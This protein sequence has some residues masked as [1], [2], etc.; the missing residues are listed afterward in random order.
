MSKLDLETYGT[1]QELHCHT[2]FCDGKSTPEEMVLAAI[3]KGL[4]RIG[5]SGHAPMCFPEEYPMSEQGAED[6]RATVAALK[7]TYAGRIEI[8]CGI[9]QDIY[10]VPIAKPYD[11]VIGAAHY[12]KVGGEYIPVDLEP[13][14][15]TEGCR[16]HFGG[17]FLTMCEAYYLEVEKVAELKPDII[18]HI[19]LITKFNQGGV[20]FDES[21]PRYLAAAYRAIDA[22][23]PTGAIFEINT[24][25]ISR[26]YRT[27]PYPSLPLLRYIRSKGGRV[28]LTGDT[29]QASN[30]CYA[31]EQWEHLL[32]E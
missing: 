26:G 6:Y 8:L 20:L 23:I 14:A 28:L 22:L 19:D 7:D 13:Q 5:F 24:G 30:L 32:R 27:A 11:Y 10:S 17:D 3:D 25:G 18:A 16:K 1:R 31:F 4:C 9:E 21:H 29:H 2:T 15:L 12:I